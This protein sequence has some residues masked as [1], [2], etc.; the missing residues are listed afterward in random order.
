MR[1]IHPHWQSTESIGPGQSKRAK[2]KAASRRPAALLGILLV[3]GMGFV[4]LGGT[5][6]FTA[7]TPSETRTGEST[8][9]PEG[10]VEVV[11]TAEG[12]DPKTV[13][14]RPGGTIVWR[15]NSTLPHIIE[16]KEVKGTNDQS[17]YTPAIF[18]DT[19]ESF[20]VSP[21]QTPGTY[22]Y[23]S[24]TASDINGEI[25]VISADVQN[26]VPG[27]PS[28]T[29]PL[30]SNEPPAET[31]QN[32]TAS[33]KAIITSDDPLLAG[34]SLNQD[35][36]KD[37]YAPRGSQDARVPTNPYTVDSRVSVNRD[38]LH[39]GA[40]SLP[41]PNRQ[42]ATGSNAWVLALVITGILALTYWMMPKR[43]EKS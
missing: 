30:T 4:A 27:T 39:T 10:S 26:D 31:P 22:A 14:V 20:T 18:P 38:P 25:Q 11:I 33:S 28:G 41:R 34:F 15:N 36:P 43:R 23:V 3:T 21:S 7:Q 37:P 1:D 16:S 2:P 32:N 19:S 12:L 8:S 9:L 17:L 29:D 35:L 13:T 24:V 6:L 42:P 5:S 40:P